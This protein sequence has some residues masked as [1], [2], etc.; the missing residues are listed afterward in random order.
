MQIH[1]ASTGAVLSI[2]DHQPKKLEI[3]LLSQ[4]VFWYSLLLGT[5][6]YRMVASIIHFQLKKKKRTEIRDRAA[7]IALL[8]LGIV[9][10]FS[11]LSKHQ[12]LQ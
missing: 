3:Q 6:I 2:S 12:V 4:S 9:L 1:E 11:C 10:G 5:Y 8:F 7:S